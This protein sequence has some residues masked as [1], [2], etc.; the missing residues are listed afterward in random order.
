ML[1]VIG[2]LGFGDVNYELKTSL[3]YIL[4]CCCI[5]VYIM[6]VLFSQASSLHMWIYIYISCFTPFFD[7][8]IIE[9]PSVFIVLDFLTGWVFSS[10]LFSMFQLNQFSYI[11]IV[12]WMR[13]FA[14]FPFQFNISCSEITR[15]LFLKVDDEADSATVGML[16]R[17][18][19]LFEFHKHLHLLANSM[20]FP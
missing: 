9:F 15:C 4:D 1:M 10:L 11:S 14:F 12:C 13:N 6:H 20:I 3:P 18:V 17:F 7:I 16:M 8:A 19:P 5:D 2:N